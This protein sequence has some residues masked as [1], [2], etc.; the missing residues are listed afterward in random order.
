M[1]PTADTRERIIDKAFQLML[2][3]GFNG[4]SYRDIAEPLGVKNA[5]IHYHFPNKT[6]LVKALLEEN[7]QTLRRSTSEISCT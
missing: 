5:A 3:R 1:T 4:F 2:Q 7:H 6:D